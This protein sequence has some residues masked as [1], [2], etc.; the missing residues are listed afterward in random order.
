VLAAYDFGGFGV[1]VDVGGGT[2]A[3]LADV[4]VSNPNGRGVLFDQPHVVSGAPALLAAAG[5]DTRCEVVG[6]SFFESVPDGGD[7]YVMKAV[8]HD[9]DDERAAMVLRTCRRHLA[10]SAMLLLVERVLARPN[11]GAA[12]KLSDLN[13]LVS[14]G[15][16]ERTF[17][18]YVALL[19]RCGFGAV[20]EVP[21]RGP[22]SVIEALP[23]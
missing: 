11:E 3:L 10:L 19:E 13:M 7:A 16:R 12:S 23:T 2:G 4:L 20:R 8:I 9:W 17:P 6:G 5:V 22:V 1:V 14:P 18:E 21:T 15:G